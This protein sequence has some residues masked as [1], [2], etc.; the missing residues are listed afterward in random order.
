M[1]RRRPLKAGQRHMTAIRYRDRVVASTVRPSAGVVG[2]GFLLLQTVSGLMWLEYA[3]SSWREV[4]V[5]LTGPHAHL[6]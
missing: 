4:L 5:P 2:A 1:E 6:T 3:A